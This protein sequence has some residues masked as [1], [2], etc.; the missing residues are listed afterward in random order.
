MGLVVALRGGGGFRGGGGAQEG[1]ERVHGGAEEVRE[2][3]VGPLLLSTH[4]WSKGMLSMIILSPL[5]LCGSHRKWLLQ[6]G[7]WVVH[8][9]GEWGTRC[10]GS[11]GEVVAG[12]VL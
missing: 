8:G 2:A 5:S 6:V 4:R 3:T 10:S 9:G 11:M 12:G 1:S 7:S